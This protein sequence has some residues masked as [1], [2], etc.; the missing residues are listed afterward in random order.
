M[1]KL[2]AKEKEKVSFPRGYKAVFITELFNKQYLWCTDPEGA[3]FLEPV[4]VIDDQR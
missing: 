3:W 1:R 4:G 2:T